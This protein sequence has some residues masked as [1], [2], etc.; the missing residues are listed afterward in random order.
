[1][2][3]NWIVVCSRVFVPLCDDNM[4]FYFGS[5]FD[6]YYLTK[7]NTNKHIRTHQ[8]SQWPLIIWR[9]RMTLRIGHLSQSR[10]L[11]MYV[12]VDKPQNSVHCSY[13]P[14]IYIYIFIYIIPIMSI[15][16]L[17]IMSYWIERLPFLNGPMLHKQ[18]TFNGNCRWISSGSVPNHL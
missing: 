10:P 11:C 1:M 6:W 13:K 18:S 14:L 4:S 9:S 8:P 12:F 2:T 5:V 7:Q 15:L 3:Y 16:P 17:Y